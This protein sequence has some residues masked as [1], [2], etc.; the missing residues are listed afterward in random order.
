MDG[1]GMGFSIPLPRTVPNA[2]LAIAPALRVAP[3][4]RSAI[5][6]A[7]QAVSLRSLLPPTFLP[8]LTA[9]HI[10]LMRDRFDVRWIHAGAVRTVRATQT[11]RAIMAAMVRFQAIWDWAN[12]LLI[13]P[14]VSLHQLS[15]ATP[16][17]KLA[18][19]MSV[20]CAEPAPALVIKNANLSPKAGRQA[21]IAKGGSGARLREHRTY[22]RCHAPGDYGLA[23]AICLGRL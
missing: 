3:Q 18:V 2:S 1:G 6:M 23:G 9:T 16:N 4:V 15:G 8:S 14:T 10:L 21:G 5:R 7:P 12:K 17:A 22:L 20:S 19:T 13:T 11:I